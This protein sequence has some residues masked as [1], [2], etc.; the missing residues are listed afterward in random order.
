MGNLTI[1]FTFVM[2]L[3]VFMFL[4][5][6]AVIN[7]DPSSDTFIFSEEGTLLTEFDSGG[8]VL[9][10]SD[11]ALKNAIPGSGVAVSPTDNNYISDT[12][13]SIKSWFLGLPGINYLYQ[14]FASPYVILKSLNLPNDFVFGIGTLWYILSLFITVAFFWGGRD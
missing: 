2:V 1:A 10:T 8:H 14:L 11:E 5:Q 12:L 13:G 7:I 9:D 4:T 6:A 3:N